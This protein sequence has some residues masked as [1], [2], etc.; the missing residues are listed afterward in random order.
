MRLV[1][2][3]LA[4]WACQKSSSISGAG[5]GGGSGSGSDVIAECGSAGDCVLAAATCCECPTFA[6]N[7]D[8]PSHAGCVGI[9]CNPEPV[10]PTCPGNV[11]AQCQ[12]NHCVLA[13]TPMVCPSTCADGFVIDATTG[14]LSCTCAMNNTPSCGVDSDCVRTRA[15]CCGCTHGGEDTAVPASEQ[16][17]FDASLDCPTDPSCPSTDSC[18]ADLTARCIEGA[19]ELAPATPTGACGSAALASCPAGQSCWINNDLTASQLGLGVCM[20]ST[21]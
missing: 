13:C 17:S 4:L 2:L 20:S 3:L 5:G 18:A 15:D 14:C 9:T 12:N 6:A 1:L 10:P 21:E 7:V 19:C 8:D 16:A 11:E